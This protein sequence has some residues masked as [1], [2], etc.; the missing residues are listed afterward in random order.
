M[1]RISTL[2]ANQIS[3]ELQ[4][5]KR[6][7]GKTQKEIKDK[8]GNVS[9]LRKELYKLE[10]K[11][12][13]IK[14]KVENVKSIYINNVA[15]TEEELIKMVNYYH[16]HVTNVS[17]I[18]KI[19]NDIMKEILLRGTSNTIKNLCLTD[20]TYKKICSDNA[21]WHDKFEHDQLPQLVI[22]KT[23]K[24]KGHDLQIP[25]TMKYLPKTINKWMIAYDKMLKS[26][27]IAVK[28]VDNILDTK[29]FT[30][31]TPVIDIHMALWLPKAMIDYVNN[32]DS[33]EINL[34]FEITDD[35][36][37]LELITS[38][39]EDSEDENASSLKLQLSKTEFINYLTLLLYYQGD[40]EDFMLSDG[41]DVSYFKDDLLNTGL[42][43]KKFPN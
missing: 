20:T 36:F 26:H 25:R 13:T 7:S 10:K 14:D 42:M 3:K 32:D 34:Y 9:S 16:E 19:N 37:Y 35:K 8:V 43:K 39:E 22:I 33:H 40:D 23:H 29:E 31:F 24:H 38:E 18:P 2:N 28:L 12:D 11:N 41:D 21:F 15:Y 17:K 6:Y 30:E 4:G 5:Y 27:N 1:D